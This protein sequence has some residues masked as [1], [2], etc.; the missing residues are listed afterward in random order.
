MFFLVLQKEV[1]KMYRLGKISISQGSVESGHELEV[2]IDRL[3][4]EFEGTLAGK[5]LLQVF[6]E[7]DG[8]LFEQADAHSQYAC[9]L[10]ECVH[11]A[12]PYS[13]DW[14][15][16][17][18][19]RVLHRDNK[20]TYLDGTTHSVVSICGRLAI[21]S[22]VQLE[23]EEHE[24]SIKEMLIPVIKELQAFFNIDYLLANK[25]FYIPVQC[26]PSEK[27]QQDNVNR[28]LPIYKQNIEVLTE[29]G[30]QKTG[31]DGYVLKVEEF[32]LE[33]Q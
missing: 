2:E 24:L 11:I 3:D 20:V 17:K 23:S 10:L 7:R 12:E 25:Q 21:L 28:L 27:E 18:Y 16:S 26:K 1:N 30:F 5:V 9:N 32:S 22:D 13:D 4:E 33:N 6:D 29:A 15:K 31:K 19:L 14:E 8:N